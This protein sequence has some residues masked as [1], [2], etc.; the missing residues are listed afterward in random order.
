MLEVQKLLDYMDAGSRVIHRA[1]T[2]DCMDVGG[3][4]MHGAITEEQITAIVKQSNRI[5]RKLP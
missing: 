5:T 2:D 4:V 1:I 3:R